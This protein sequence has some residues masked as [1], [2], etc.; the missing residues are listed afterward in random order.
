MVVCFGFI[1]F[2]HELQ[3][4]NMNMTSFLLQ[5][6]YYWKLKLNYLSCRTFTAIW[7]TCPNY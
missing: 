2:F 5:Q 1:L 4:S 6:S 3:L 7:A